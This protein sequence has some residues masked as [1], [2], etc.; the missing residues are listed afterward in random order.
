MKQQKKTANIIAFSLFGN[1]ILS[2][3][4]LN[5]L[6]LNSLRKTF[7]C[8]CVIQ[9]LKVKLSSFDRRRL[10][11]ISVLPPAASKHI[12]PPASTT[13]VQLEVWLTLEVR[14]LA[15][16]VSE[17]PGRSISPGPG[18]CVRRIVRVSAQP[19]PVTGH[20]GDEVVSVFIVNGGQHCSILATL[21]GG[22]VDGDLL[23]NK[24]VA[25]A[26]EVRVSFRTVDT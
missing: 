14:L 24:L 16:P 4:K 21:P 6:Y 13:E 15:S 26:R 23:V 5:F 8:C 20:G 17:V 9:G 1:Q 12:V 22:S 10:A 2:V 18:C 7:F 11:N 3:E 19:D 25:G